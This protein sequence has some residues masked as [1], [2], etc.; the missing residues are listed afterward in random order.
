MYGNAYSTA[1]VKVNIAVTQI[2]K[3]KRVSRP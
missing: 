1:D 2:K 3:R